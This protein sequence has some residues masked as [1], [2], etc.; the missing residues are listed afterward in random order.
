MDDLQVAGL[1]HNESEV[2]RALLDLGPSLAGKVSR[3][4]GLHRRTVYDTTETLITK[5]LISYILENHRRIFRANDPQHIISMLDEKR[6]KLLP[7]VASLE[8]LYARTKKTEQTMVFKG[9]NAIKNVFE[10]QLEH[11]EILI[12]GA[13]PKAYDIMPYYFKWYN[14][15][16]KKK[17][18]HLKIIT[19]D[20]TIQPKGFVDIRYLPASHA[21]PVTMN[22]YGDTVAIIAW[23][24][25]PFAIVI[26][27]AM[28][29]DSYR[30]YFSIVWKSAKK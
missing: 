6:E 12:I 23:S 5:G 17:R 20:R 19:N 4:T 13:T 9:K 24:L 1:T 7:L 29:A 22:I 3:R 26:Q 28:I 27:N 21:S 11:K 14:Q 10:R 30:A 16:R 2:Y 25:T 15:R 8:T 18:V